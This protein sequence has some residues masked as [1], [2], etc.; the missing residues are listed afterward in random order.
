MV[1]TP[2]QFKTAATSIGICAEARSFVINYDTNDVTGAWENLASESWY[3]DIVVRLHYH[4][5]ISDAKLRDILVACLME[6]KQVVED[7]A[8]KPIV[9][10]KPAAVQ[11]PKMINDLLVLLTSAKPDEVAR[12]G[13]YMN[14]LMSSVPLAVIRWSLQQYGHEV[15]D[16]VRNT[17]HLHT[18]TAV[19]STF[20]AEEVKAALV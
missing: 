18:K 19:L 9:A 5:R 13:N 15:A 2:D 1:L 17:I 4:K 6:W 16:G 14:T 20:T 3:R 8:K 12:L 7:T 10:T 11:A